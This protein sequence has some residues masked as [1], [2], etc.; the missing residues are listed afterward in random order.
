MDSPM[1]CF[2]H[3]VPHFGMCFVCLMEIN[4]KLDLEITIA[5]GM[6]ICLGAEG[7]VCMRENIQH[8]EKQAIMQ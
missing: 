8:F 4:D 1:V 5:E 6:T 2:I 3:R 7:M